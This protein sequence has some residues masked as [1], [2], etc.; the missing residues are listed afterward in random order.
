MSRVKNSGSRLV[1]STSAGRLCPQCQRPVAECV[2]GKDRPAATG[3]GIVRLQ[4][5]TKGR[6]GKGVITMKVTEKTGRVV[7]ALRVSEDDDVMLMTNKGQS[8]RI[9]ASSARLTGRNAQGVILMKTK[10]GESIQDIARVVNEEDEAETEE[11]ADAGA[12]AD[13]DGTGADANPE[14]APP[15]DEQE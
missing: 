15:S 7:K 3:D 4:R 8:V 11:A 1:Y 6:G 9:K 10:D 5:E 13:G 14:T 2:C 12:I